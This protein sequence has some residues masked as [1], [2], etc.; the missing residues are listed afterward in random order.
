M[1]SLDNCC[2]GFD[3]SNVFHATGVQ[4]CPLYSCLLLIQ[5]F[6]RFL[7]FVAFYESNLVSTLPWSQL[8]TKM[9]HY[10]DGKKYNNTFDM[11]WYSCGLHFINSLLD[12][13]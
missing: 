8:L 6:V 2:Q 7:V 1:N 5:P 10:R 13:M 4:P 11:L 9:R 3:T 12:I